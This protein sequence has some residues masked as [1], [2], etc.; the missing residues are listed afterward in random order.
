METPPAGPAT[1]GRS[2]QEVNV[3][4]YQ[5]TTPIFILI[6]LLVFAPRCFQVVTADASLLFDVFNCTLGG[7][8]GYRLASTAIKAKNYIVSIATLDC[9]R[10]PRTTTTS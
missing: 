1:G 7:T 4:C 3:N 9:T 6:F 5:L 8:G 2:A 10:C